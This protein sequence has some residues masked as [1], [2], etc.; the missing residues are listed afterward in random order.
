MSNA[1][2]RIIPY[3]EGDGPQRTQ[4]T[5]V[6]VGDQEING[7]TGITLR[8][9]VNDLW[10]A[11]IECHVLPPELAATGLF[12]TERRSLYRR[13]ADWIAGKR[14]VTSLRDNAFYYERVPK[15]PSGDED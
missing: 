12:V 1:H 2:L 13:I 15:L 5:M 8:A 4:G 6:L 7:V 10:R 11:T 14:D 3:V 9:D